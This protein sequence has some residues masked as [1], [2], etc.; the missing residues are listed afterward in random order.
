MHFCSYKQN[1]KLPA[2]F[3]GPWNDMDSQRTSG[4]LQY[5]NCA[6]FSTIKFI[7]TKNSNLAMML[8]YHC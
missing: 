6:G 7:K 3:V 2:E 8:T 5:N 4:I 1:N